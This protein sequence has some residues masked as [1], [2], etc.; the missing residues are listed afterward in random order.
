MAQLILASR[1]WVL[2]QRRSGRNPT[3]SDR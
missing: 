1:Y 3:E 2:V